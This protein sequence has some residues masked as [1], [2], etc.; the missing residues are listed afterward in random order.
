[1]ALRSL[2]TGPDRA[3]PGRG[4]NV[5]SAVQDDDQALLARVRLRDGAAFR[6]LVVRHLPMLLAIARRMLRDDAEAEDVAQEALI[7][8]WQGGANLELGTGGAKPWLRRVVSNLCIDKLRA[9]R[10]ID[11]TDEVPE[12]E[13]EADQLAV[14]EEGETAARVDVA[15]KTLPERQRLALTLFHY[16]GLSQVEVGE[17]LGVS[18]EAVESLLSRARRSLRTLLKDD[19]RSLLP[20]TAR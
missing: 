5:S 8:L 19:W 12:Q 1:M 16:E 15:L 4:V 17:I 11:V 14:L 20:E 6:L 9:G 13:I 10:R 7:K 2:E 18:D 3:V